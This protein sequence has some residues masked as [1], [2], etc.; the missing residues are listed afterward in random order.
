[1]KPIRAEE[2]VDD[3]IRTRA[4]NHASKAHLKD[5]RFRLKRFAGAFQCEIHLIR[6][7]QV[8]DFLTSLKLFAGPSRC[9][10]R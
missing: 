3:L 2:L 8:Q 9:F 1:M 7:A 5:L 6:P 4:G 10:V